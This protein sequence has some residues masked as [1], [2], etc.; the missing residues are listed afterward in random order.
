[1]FA[2]QLSIKHQSRMDLIGIQAALH[3][4]L[5]HL[6]PTL[7]VANHEIYFFKQNSRVDESLPIP[8]AW[9]ALFAI[10]ANQYS[11][12]RKELEKIMNTMHRSLI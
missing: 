5:R 8:R 4:H 9:M 12:G 3:D 6:R 11:A 10:C 7:L 2:S 1:M